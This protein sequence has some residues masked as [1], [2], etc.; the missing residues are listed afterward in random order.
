ML[1]LKDNLFY[2]GTQNPSL[3]V[4]DIIMCTEFGTTYNA[5]IVKGEKTALIETCHNKFYDIFKSNVEEVCPLSEIDYVIFNHTEP[6]HSGSLEKLLAVNPDIEVFGTTAAIKFLKAISNKDFNGHV[7]KAG[8]KLDLG[9]GIDLEFIPAPN[10]HW[11]DSMFTYCSALK[12]VFTCD[13]LG[14]HYCE[15]TITD[16]FLSEPDGYWRAF[17]NYY[18]AIMG[19]FKKFVNAGLD[20]LEELEFDTVCT[21]HGP[22]LKHN[23]SEA[24]AKYRKWS[25]PTVVPN[26]AAIF[27]VSAY[28]YTE[29]MAN[30]LA[31]GLKEAGVDAH[32]Y[33]IIKTSTAEI[34]EKIETSQMFMFG[35]STINKDAVK[36]VWDVMS[37]IDPISNA[38]KKALM[39]GSYGWSG[40]AC[41]NLQARAEGIGLKV[42]VENQ[43]VNF[44]PS[45]EDLANLKS[46]AVEF[47]KA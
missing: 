44:K 43:R 32:V 37:M 6:D 41:R 25:Q 16:D 17:K 13:F 28:G 38:G 11:S 19:P 1:K 14:S 31:Q 26:T 7:I 46:V 15:P 24:M 35:S 39:F 42:P 2:V 10:L 9:A 27:Y 45:D 21:S 4:F 8:E 34:A 5:Y 36:P 33:D 18:C 3:R 23:I 20:K 12:T 22:V 47:A 29:M 30:A 40:E